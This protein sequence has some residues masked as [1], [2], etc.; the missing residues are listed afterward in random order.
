MKKAI[1]LVIPF[2]FLLCACSTLSPKY[3]PTYQRDTVYVAT[4]DQTVQKDSIFI[5]KD[6]IIKEKGDTVYITET[7][8]KYRDRWRDREVHDTT[9]VDKVRVDTVVE[10]VEKPLTFMQK[11]FINFGKVFCV[12]LVLLLGYGILKLYTKF[13]I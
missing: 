8:T 6:R 1:I 12:I 13:K 10:T 11:F 5:F 2:C 4:H 3:V 9:Y 7:L